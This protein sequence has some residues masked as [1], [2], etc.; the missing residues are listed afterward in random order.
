MEQ[1]REILFDIILTALKEYFKN[2]EEAAD[3]KC[4]PES[5]EEDLWVF[6]KLADRTGKDLCELCDYPR[7]HT[8]VPACFN[9][10]RNSKSLKSELLN[11]CPYEKLVH[12]EP[13]Y[14]HYDEALRIDPTWVKDVVYFAYE[15]RQ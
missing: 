11:K 3:L 5:R 4:D 2:E 8:E 13:E 12:E 6:R 7:R 10:I 1:E 15:D 9:C 14:K